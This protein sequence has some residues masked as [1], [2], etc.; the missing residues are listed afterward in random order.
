MAKHLTWREIRNYLNS[1]DY[2]E[3][4]KTA[5]VFLDDMTYMIDDGGTAGMWPISFIGKAWN[6]LT[7][8][9]DEDYWKE[10]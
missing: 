4:D 7:V 2:N 9:I 6:E 3:L 1:L 8:V 10:S 5:S